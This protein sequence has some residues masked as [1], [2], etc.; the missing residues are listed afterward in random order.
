VQELLNDKLGITQDVVNTNKHADIL[1]LT[2]KMTSF[3]QAVLQQYIEDGYDTFIGH[4]AEGRGLTK[5]QVDEIG[6]GRVWA[7]ESAMNN[8][9]IDL[10]GGVDD[11]VKLAAEK[12]GLER[13]RIVQLPKIKDPLEEW[14]KEFS[15]NARMWTMKNELGENYRIY[16]E[17]K[18]LTRTKGILARLPYTIQ[19]D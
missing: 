2:R 11:A 8:G 7:A 5:E 19:I 17:L 9:L 6:Q 15:G 18:G 14:L 13:Y 10:Y 3:E 1:T 12:A 16:Q 4:V